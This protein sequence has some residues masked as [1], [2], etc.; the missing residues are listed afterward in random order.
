MKFFSMNRQWDSSWER[1]L[2]DGTYMS[3]E[4][5]LSNFQMYRSCVRQLNGLIEDDEVFQRV[6]GKVGKRASMLH[7]MV[8]LKFLGSYGN[9]AALQKIGHMM[10]FRKERSMTMSCRHVMPS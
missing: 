9:A 8:L 1:M 5:F 7:V 3:D 10:G 6:L 4:E 2:E